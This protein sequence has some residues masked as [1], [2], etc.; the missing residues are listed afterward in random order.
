MDDMV[1]AL[2]GAFRTQRLVI[3]AAESEED[4][5]FISTNLAC[6]VNR[7]LASGETL[8]LHTKETMR[9]R[10]ENQMQAHKAILLCLPTANDHNGQPIGVMYLQREGHR[11]MTTSINITAEHQDKGYGR[12]ALNWALEFAFRWADQ[13]RFEIAAMSYNE[14]A[15]HLYRSLGFVEEGVSR[16]A[17]FMNGKWH[18]VLKFGMLASEWW[19]RQSAT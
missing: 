19:G 10:V 1:N 13:H 2:Q 15:V 17:V 16:K 11:L 9:A 3:R 8:Q 5:E 18:D 7:G 6:P 4:E 12:E 14:R